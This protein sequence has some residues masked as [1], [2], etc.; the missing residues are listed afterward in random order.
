M[1]ARSTYSTSFILLVVKCLL[2]TS[3]LFFATG[4]I[5]AQTL[6]NHLKRFTSVLSNRNLDSLRLFID[7]NRI[8]V[9]IAP[10]SGSYLS[11]LQTLAV[12]ESF[13]RFQLPVSFLYL[14]VREEGR[15]GIALGT[16]IVTE[17]SRSLSRKVN[18]G[19]QKDNRDHWLLG[20]ISIH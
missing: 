19:F 10:K 20:R 3:F 2:L 17:N 14:L 13:F 9:E 12:I 5:Q 18:F 7:P 1:N 11:P 6:A 16:L 8:Y 15:S 4:M